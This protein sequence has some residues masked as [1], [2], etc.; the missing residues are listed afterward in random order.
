MFALITALVT[1]SMAVGDVTVNTLGDA[2]IVSETSGARDDNNGGNTT[3]GALIGV[4]A[5]GVDNFMI[6]D[7]SDLSSAA[8]ETVSGATVEIFV[9]TGFSHSQ[10]GGPGDVITLSEI[11]LSN[12]GWSQGSGVIT[13]TDNQA[14]DGSVS[15]LNRIQF[16][17]SGTTMPWMNASGTGVSN[18]LGSLTTLDSTNGWNS[19]SA[20]VSMLFSIDAA[21]AQGWVDNG[22]GGLALSATDDGDGMSRFNM[23]TH[24]SGQLGAAITFHV[25]PE[26]ASLGTL[27]M[28]SA[29]AL[30][31]RRRG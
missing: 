29:F 16:D 12:L 3:T 4:N 28:L 5:G 10:H 17:T 1:G 2:R 9:A 13:G 21:T 15:F 30:L 31:R 7:F 26:P 23:R 24:N 18:L 6:Y 14:D 27:G 11:A 20:P 22:L 25:V 8:G 19:G